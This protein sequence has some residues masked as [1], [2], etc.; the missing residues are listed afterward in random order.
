MR[1]YSQ[2]REVFTPYMSFLDALMNVGWD[3]LPSLVAP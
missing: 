1:E 2:G 3:G